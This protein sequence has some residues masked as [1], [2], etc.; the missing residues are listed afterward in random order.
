[1]KKRMTLQGAG[2]GPRCANE[3][4]NSDQRLNPKCVNGARTS[5]NSG[6]TG[7]RRFG[8]AWSDGPD[9]GGPRRFTNTAVPRFDGTGCWQQHLLVFRA[10]MKSNGWSTTTAALQLFAHL[11]GEALHVALLMPDKIREC[12]KDLVT[13]LSEYYTTPGRLAVVRRQFENACRR[14][15]VDP[16]TFATEL[17]ILAVRGFADMNEKARD[18]MIRNKFIEAQRSCELRRHLDGAAEEASIGNIVDSCRIW[19]SHAETVFVWSVRQDLD[20]SQSMS[21][22]TVSDKSLLATS[23]S[24]RLHQDVGCVIPTTRGPPPRVAHSSVDRELLMQNVL[25][26][27]R[28]RRTAGTGVG[29]Y[30]AGHASGW[31]NHG[32]EDISAGTST[33]RGSDPTNERSVETWP[34]LLLR[35]TRS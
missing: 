34:V 18:L 8:R 13:S 22:V 19:E 24:T 14:P 17:G 11:D 6:S 25:E 10:I 5:Q 9:A 15:G 12:W 7:P 32:R 28:A 16:A 33:S 30:V 4:N 31:I 27:V 20:C 29:I 35:T 21:Q 3:K 23:G 26:A 2:F 1:M